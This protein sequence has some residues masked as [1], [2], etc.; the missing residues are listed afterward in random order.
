M[1][2]KPRQQ[3]YVAC[4][5]AEMLATPHQLQMPAPVTAFLYFQQDRS[6]ELWKE[7]CPQ[8][9]DLH[10]QASPM[11]TR[12]R[13]LPCIGLFPDSTHQGRRWSDLLF[14]VRRK[15]SGCL[16]GL[17]N[18]GHM[19]LS[20]MYIHMNLQAR[21][22]W[23]AHMYMYSHLCTWELFS[24]V[25]QAKRNKQLLLVVGCLYPSSLPACTFNGWSWFII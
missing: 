3:G 12:M 15:T 19:N 24:T 21:V 22:V 14:L 10:E 9:S 2:L 7:Q 23:P 13:E 17:H 6:L 5:H 1:S 16:L 11:R 4:P 18:T 20:F 8:V 25:L